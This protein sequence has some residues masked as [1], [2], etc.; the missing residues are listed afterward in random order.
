[1]YEAKGAVPHAENVR[2]RL[3]ELEAG[4]L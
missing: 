1:M 2:R 4:P 3:A